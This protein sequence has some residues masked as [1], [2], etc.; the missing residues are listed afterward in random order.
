MLAVLAWQSSW[1]PP[2]AQLHPVM[3]P[4]W[5][6]PPYQPLVISPRDHRLSRHSHYS[7]RVIIL[8]WVKRLSNVLL[9]RLRCLPMT[10]RRYSSHVH[11]KAHHCGNSHAI[12]DHTVLPAT[13]QRLHSRPYPGQSWHSIN[14]PQRDAGLCWLSWLV[15]C[16]YGISTLRQSP[17]PVV[18]RLK[19]L[20]TALSLCHAAHQ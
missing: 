3:Q 17:V 13:R 1:K 14:R 12:W 10:S 18:T 5:Q 16:R 11:S 7:Q 9:A 19:I 4:P 15:T 20:P 2:V 8:D 6:L